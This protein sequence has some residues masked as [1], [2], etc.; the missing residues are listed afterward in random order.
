MVFAFYHPVLALYD[1]NNWKLVKIIKLPD[2]ILSIKHA[3]FVSLP[4][5]GGNSKILAILT[6]Q[7]RIHFY[8]LEENAIIS[9]L[10]CDMEIRRF[11]CSINGKYIACVRCK[12]DI[13]IFNLNQYI[14]P[15]KLIKVQPVKKYKSRTSDF[16]KLCLIKNQIS[17][18]LNVDKLKMILKKYGEYPDVHRLKIWENLLQ[19][20][21]NTEQYNKI[22][23]RVPL[24]SFIDLYDK[25][26]LENKNTIKNV[27][28]LLN[29]LVNWCPFFGHVHYL[30]VLTFPFARVLE[31][32]PIVCFEITCTLISK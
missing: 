3:E 29:N 11:F 10:C 31:N 26:P 5:D 27:R 24:E 4:F 2:Y 28:K 13:E 32:M 9:E 23:N 1:T 21:N 20:P 16:R 14:E 8:N 12:N 19:L 7:R 18:I 25:Y 6:G 17:T 30:P 22:I 15:P